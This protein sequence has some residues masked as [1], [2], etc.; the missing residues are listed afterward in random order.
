MLY[1][2]QRTLCMW[3][4]RGILTHTHTRRLTPV[5]Q[6]NLGYPVSL[7]FLAVILKQ[8]ILHALPVA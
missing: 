8:E 5:L 7:D 2:R 3:C 4:E 1:T 6:E